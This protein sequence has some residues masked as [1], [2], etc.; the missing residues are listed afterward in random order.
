VESALTNITLVVYTSDKRYVYEKSSM[1]FIVVTLPSIRTSTSSMPNI[2]TIRPWILKG[3]DNAVYRLG[4]QRFWTLSS[5][6]YSKGEKLGAT[7][8][9]GSVRNN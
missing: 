3:S 4:L 7:Y 9:V 8:F 1:H 5:S 2:V 6:Q